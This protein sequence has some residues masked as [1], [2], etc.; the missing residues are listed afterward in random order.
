MSTDEMTETNAA[1]R[2]INELRKLT[3]ITAELVHEFSTRAPLFENWS[4]GGLPT[5]LGYSL[6]QFHPTDRSDIAAVTSQAKTIARGIGS[7]WVRERETYGYSYRGKLTLPK[8]GFTLTIILHSAE[9][10]AEKPNF[11]SLDTEP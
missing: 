3:E 5:G 10:G 11:L 1:S 4:T 2:L 9:L 6:M 8:T 7:Y